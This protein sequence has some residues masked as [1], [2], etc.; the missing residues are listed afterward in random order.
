MPLHC[1]IKHYY[2]QMFYIT[3]ENEWKQRFPCSFFTEK[4]LS[5]P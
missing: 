1:Q 2:I 4:F 5:S 3:F